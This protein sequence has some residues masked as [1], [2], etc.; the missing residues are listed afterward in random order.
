MLFPI[1]KAPKNDQ[2]EDLLRKRQCAACPMSRYK[3]ADPVIPPDVDVMVISE[4]LGYEINSTHTGGFKTAHVH[5]VEC[6][7]PSYMGGIKTNND[8]G[9]VKCCSGR[10][11]DMI[12]QHKPKIVVAVGNSIF[13]EL[14][15]ACGVSAGYGDY[16][17]T[18]FPTR[19]KGHDFWLILIPD[20][21]IRSTMIEHKKMFAS[22]I[23]KKP[24]VLVGDSKGVSYVT[25]NSQ[26]AAAFAAL[27]KYDAV[28][29]DIE[30]NGLRPYIT[31]GKL[32]TIAIGTYD[33]TIVFPLWH[34]QR[35]AGF[36]S[37]EVMKQLIDLVQ[38]RKVIFHNG[39]FELE[40]FI[41][42]MGE[43][44]A[45][46]G[47]WQDTMAQAHVLSAG[48]KSLDA[49]IRKFFGFNLK[50][51]NQIDVADLDNCPLDHVMRYNGM[52]TKYTHK[53]WLE[54]APEVISEGL[55]EVYER[56]LTLIPAV[57][58]MQ[59]D[60]LPLD[61]D[62]I[63]SE[64]IK[65]KA[66]IARYEA[67]FKMH[68]QVSGMISKYGTC[69][70]TSDKDIERL[71]HEFFNV[72]DSV[73]SFG[74]ETLSELHLPIADTILKLREHNKI[75]GTYLAPCAP[76]D[77]HPSAGKHVYPDGMLHPIFN[78]MRAK[79][80]RL[81]SE[82]P[83]AQNF[84]SHGGN[85]YIK[86]IVIAQCLNLLPAD[87]SF[88]SIDFGQL[89]YRIIAALS[90]DPKMI[91]AILNGLDIHGFWASKMDSMFPG[92]F[93]KNPTDPKEFKAFRNK[94]KNK[95][96][97][98]MC[99]GSSFNSIGEAMG[100]TDRR[101]MNAIGEEFWSE[102]GRVQEWHK[103]L[104]FQMNRDG[105]VYNAF[106]RK[107][108][109]PLGHNQIINYPIQGTATD[110]VNIAMA[111]LCR[112]SVETGK[113]WLRPRINIHDDLSFIV[114]TIYLNELLSTVIPKMLDTRLLKFLPIPLIVEVAVGSHWGD[115]Q[116]VGSFSSR[117]IYGDT[118]L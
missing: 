54:Q 108:R 43:N 82:G 111:A 61:Q 93:L 15:A 45:Y 67:D 83:N 70:P 88:V 60:G 66:L 81:T 6:S 116:E 42:Y 34:S 117:D 19:Y 96:V 3:G 28:A 52:D 94:C 31:G 95:F 49:C 24:N 18:P 39:A 102:H 40:H 80:S 53:L 46:L 23:A 29:V 11:L 106:G 73:V 51:L 12:E 16:D 72:P 27:K 58:L 113:S 65:Q 22:A 109:A 55:Q 57:C 36:D 56:Q 91:N 98:P 14:E 76:G 21:N 84:P 10:K 85:K 20:F 105:V 75:Y 104:E 37:D 77:D 114:P 86:N 50:K 41:H 9:V 79:T 90:K 62:F 33:E 13:N 17:W 63:S 5:W 26:I 118:W 112:M 7:P 78:T 44:F 32:L 64:I 89:E 107:F 59:N 103:E 48:P 99:F 74:E 35:P 2:I 92:A 30:T 97:F 69:K 68:P 8:A 71:F 110:I 115:V 100:I 101:K 87:C 1:K 4:K 47:D 38:G 25:D